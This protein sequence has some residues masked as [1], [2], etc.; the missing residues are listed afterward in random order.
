[1]QPLADVDG[2]AMLLAG[3]CAGDERAF[4]RLIDLYQS[5]MMRVARIYV[6]S[7]ATAED[8]V[9]ETLLA[10]LEGIDRFEGRSSLKTWMFRILANR[11]KTAGQRERRCRPDTSRAMGDDGPSVPRERFLSRGEDAEWAGHWKHEVSSWGRSGDDVVV[12]AEAARVAHEEIARL[13]TTQR[14]VVVLRDVEDW[15]AADVCRVLELSES[16]QRVLLHRG[17]STVRHR[18]ESYYA[19]E[20]STHRSHAP[21]RRC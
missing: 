5:P 20:F 1:M 21:S 6:S 2:D 14:L 3:L 18:L 4:A 9:Q 12:D 10:V 11:A 16:N 17:R 8:V 19:E 15:S 13:P 7:H